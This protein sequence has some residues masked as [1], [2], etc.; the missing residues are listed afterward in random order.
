MKNCSGSVS[1]PGPR[2]RLPALSHPIPRA[3]RFQADLLRHPA[4]NRALRPSISH[5]H[6]RTPLPPLPPL[7]GTRV[8]PIFRES[9]LFPWEKVIFCWLINTKH[10]RPPSCQIVLNHNMPCSWTSVLAVNNCDNFVTLANFVPLPVSLPG[11]LMRVLTSLH[12]SRLALSPC[13]MPPLFAYC[14]SSSPCEVTQEKDFPLV[15]Q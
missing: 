15:L 13:V 12:A 1:L 9:G 10:H 7:R 5:V 2:A 14:L 4:R 8:M 3:F 6:L 11:A